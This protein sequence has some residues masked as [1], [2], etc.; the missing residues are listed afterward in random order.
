MVVI[1]RRGAVECESEGF[2]AAL[3]CQLAMAEI[4]DCGIGDF[5]GGEDLLDG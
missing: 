4:V 1:R 3:P 5:T 2:S